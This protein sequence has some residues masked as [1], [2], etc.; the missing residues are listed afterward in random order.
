MDRHGSAPVRKD[1]DA[2]SV[3]REK[4]RHAGPR[5]PLRFVTL[6]GLAMAACGGGAS[7]TARVASTSTTTA[8]GPTTT[9][10]AVTTS[11]AP[12]TTAATGTSTTAVGP[13]PACPSS[14]LPPNISNVTTAPGRF[15]GDG[16]PDVLK[17]YQSAGVW[18]LRVELSAGGEV[19]VTVP[20]VG[21]GDSVK[22]VGGFSIDA[23]LAGGYSTLVGIWKT[24]GFCQLTRMTV[25]GNPSTFPVGASVRKRV[26]LRC[27]AGTALQV[28]ETE[29]ND[30][31]QYMGT[32]ANFDVVGNTLVLANTSPPQVIAATDP[33]LAP[34]G[35]FTCG[36]LRHP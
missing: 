16:Q 13:G 18:H 31:T 32:I 15:D 33:N 7:P 35:M 22:A 19:D 30:G 11:Q 20:N 8:G 36:S 10:A 27:I 12:T 25:G 26:G 1:D 29:S 14:S 28:L 34:Y 21:A 3:T 5:W 4:A 23:S 2:R 9:V 24:G 17:A 6:P